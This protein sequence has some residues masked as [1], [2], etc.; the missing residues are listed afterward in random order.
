MINKLSIAILIY[1]QF[2]SFSLTA[3]T[4]N[5]STGSRQFK[6][7]QLQED[8]RILIKTL[9][10]AYPSTY[11]YNN[12]KDIELFFTK[13]LSRLNKAMTEGEF[14]P[15][16]AATTA[17]MKDEHIIPTPS[18]VYY[19]SIYKRLN[20]FMPF[21]IKIIQNKMYVCKSVAPKLKT[22]TEILAINGAPAATIIQKLTA[23]IQRDG[24][25]KT[26]LYRHLEDYSPTQNENLFDLY[27][28]FFYA[29][30]EKFTVE[31]KT[32][33]GD[34]LKVVSKSLNYNEY[35][36]F[37]NERIL[38][39]LPLTFKSISNDVSYLSI[40]SFHSYYR[41]IYK[42]DFD[43]LFEKIFAGLDS[44]KTKNL[45]LD[46]RHCE[47]GDNSNLSLLSYL[48]NKPFSVIKYLEVGYSG[49]PSTSQYFED[50]LNAYQPDSLLYRNNYGMYRLK[51]QYEKNVPGYTIIEPKP[52]YF[53]GN[54]YVLTSGATGSAA[55]VVSSIL[56]NSKRATFV[57]EETGGA[58]EGPTALNVSILVLPNTKI[59]V[60]IPH[61]KEQLNVKYVHGRGVIPDYAIEEDAQ[62]LV[63]NT[64]TQ[65]DF[66]LKLINDKHTQNHH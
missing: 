64:D 20:W 55:A 58:M 60:E 18:S 38:H 52:N 36:A 19:D 41:E 54:I 16:V 62:D 11:R 29:L 56:R 46:L 39:D 28:S 1:F 26:F 34:S 22:G 61:I 49:L 65:L 66:T 3:Q 12:Q 63:N 42:Q 48:M 8:Y 51:S 40:S 21:S 31:I 45:I 7:K 50:T 33:K 35:K 17:N 59:K 57:G 4:T 25:I 9:H 37:Y 14:F 5:D 44:S 15:I 13:N 32:I 53:K 43:T 47:G 27:Y 2:Y 24:Y 6:P 30:P 10:G 23:Y